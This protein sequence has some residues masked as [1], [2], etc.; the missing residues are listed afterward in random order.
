MSGDPSL[1]PGDSPHDKSL[2][3][4][5]HRSQPINNGESDPL[6]PDPAELSPVA[7]DVADDQ[8]DP[9]IAAGALDAARSIAGGRARVLGAQKRRRRLRNPDGPTYSGAGSDERDPARLGSIVGRALPEL[10]WVKPLAEARRL[11]AR[12]SRA[13]ANRSA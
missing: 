6:S 4:P 12:T 10:G 11:S 7:V 1:I 9:D 8:R 2:K 5:V 3:K 13:A